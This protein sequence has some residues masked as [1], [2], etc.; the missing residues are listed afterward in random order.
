MLAPDGDHEHYHVSR[1]KQEGG[2]DPVVDLVGAVEEGEAEGQHREKKGQER[3][4]GT[5]GIGANVVEP[6]DLVA[7]R[8]GAGLAQQRS[9]VEA[10]G[11]GVI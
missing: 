9:V 6:M 11:I 10:S 7:G 1:R 3:F 8:H 4:D 5:C 2:G